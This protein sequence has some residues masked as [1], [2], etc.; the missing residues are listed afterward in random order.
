[1]IRI[2]TS[3]ALLPYLLNYN[4][5][6]RHRSPSVHMHQV[7]PR[8]ANGFALW[9][10]VQTVTGLLAI[11]SIFDR[12][13]A[14][15]YQCT[16]QKAISLKVPLAFFPRCIPNKLVSVLTLESVDPLK[17]RS[18]WAVRQK[19]FYLSD[20]NPFQWSMKIK[21]VVKLVESHCFFCL[22]RIDGEFTIKSIGQL[23]KI[24]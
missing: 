21:W 5:K 9:D 4:G 22:I 18:I 2:S 7:E 3:R 20:K 15:T 8:S 14:S 16:G 23:W 10:M 1:M 19:H 17:I 13:K 24:F 6:N 12:Y 11:R